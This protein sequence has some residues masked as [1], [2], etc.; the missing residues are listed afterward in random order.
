MAFAAS[1][2]LHV[3]LYGTYKGGQKLG[4]W[5]RLHWKPM[6]KVIEELQEARIALDDPERQPP[7]MFVDVNP[8]ATG[9]RVPPT[10]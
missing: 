2:L 9:V 4:L 5:E 6:G 10:R 7:L 8:A 1:L 3:V